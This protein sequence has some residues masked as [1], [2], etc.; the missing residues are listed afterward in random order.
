MTKQPT[1]TL[2]LHFHLELGQSRIPPVDL[3]SKDWEK[4]SCPDFVEIDEA[5]TDAGWNYQSG[6]GV[7]ALFLVSGQLIPFWTSVL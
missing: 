7:K 3:D 2:T 4:A 1:R 5:A 6:S